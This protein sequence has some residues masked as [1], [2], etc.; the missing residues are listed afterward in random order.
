VS[1]KESG[2][3]LFVITGSWNQ[4]ASANAI[5][6]SPVA[7]SSY[8]KVE[9]DIRDEVTATVTKDKV[10]YIPLKESTDQASATVWNKRYVYQLVFSGSAAPNGDEVS[11]D[12]ITLDNVGESNATSPS[13]DVP[14]EGGGPEGPV[15]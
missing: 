7:G 2:N 3:S 11:F 6:S 5:Y 8:V 1:G 15:A 9:Y 10:A 14:I 12:V 13:I 4:P